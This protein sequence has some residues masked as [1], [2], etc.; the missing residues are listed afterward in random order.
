M[1]LINFGISQ[2][3]RQAWWFLM[4]DCA[5]LAG[6]LKGTRRDLVEHRPCRVGQDH[7]LRSVHLWTALCTSMFIPQAW[8]SSFLPKGESIVINFGFAMLKLE[9]VRKV[10][11]CWLGGWNYRVIKVGKPEFERIRVLRLREEMDYPDKR[12]ILKGIPWKQR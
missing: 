12:Q 11:S 9:R 1:S 2:R 10:G 7:M 6:T 5:P 3:K 8:R 4:M